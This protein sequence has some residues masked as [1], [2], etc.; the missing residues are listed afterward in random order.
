MNILIASSNPTKIE[1]A[2]KA[3]KE[4]IKIKKLSEENI[5]VRPFKLNIYS[6]K[7]PSNVSEQPI[8]WQET[9]N[10]AYNRAQ[11]AVN[12]A[13]QKNL[14]IDY[15][16]G[17][18]GG[19]VYI[20]NIPHLINIASVINQKGT[21]YWGS[22]TFHPLPSKV[23]DF[24]LDN[25]E[26]AHFADWLSKDTDIRSKQGMVGVLTD[27]AITRLDIN[28]MAVRSALIGFIK[29]KYFKIKPNTIKPK[30]YVSAPITVGIE[31]DLPEKVMHIIEK[32]GGEV[33][34][35]HVIYAGVN[36][37]LRNKYFNI[38]GKKYLGQAKPTDN[39][40]QYAE[41]VYKL[42]TTL[43]DKA[44][45]L[46]AFLNKTSSGIAIEIQHALTK[47]ARGLPITPILGLVHKNNYN[48]ISGMLK[49]AQY[50]YFK[51][52]KYENF[53]DIEKVVKEFLG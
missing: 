18:E 5:A 21:H 12:Y 32:L 43:V 48:A 44:T 42:D 27:N 51:I 31:K 45:H 1:G 22:S 14:N 23:N 8:G 6:A 10:G 33:I 13:K 50:E 49:G 15:F 46:I 3:F 30:V 19:I 7:L 39:T 20:N 24:I 38:C 34:D 40:K 28:Y 29:T 52:V 11:N 41:F 26:L 4:F 9:L 2:K 16:V 53:K 35:K 25:K 17:I 47:P 37:K 36:Y